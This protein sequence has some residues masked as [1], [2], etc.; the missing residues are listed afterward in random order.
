VTVGRLRLRVIDLWTFS[1][2]LYAT[3]FT[4]SIEIFRKLAVLTPSAEEGGEALTIFGPEEQIFLI[5]R[6]PLQEIKTMTSI[7]RKVVR[8]LWVLDF[9]TVGEVQKP[10]FLKLQYFVCVAVIT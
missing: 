6:Q 7:F 8:R 9:Y 3:E 10:V 1:F 4:E 5:F 2:V